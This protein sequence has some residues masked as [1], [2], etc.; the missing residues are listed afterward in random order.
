MD[1]VIAPITPAGIPA[2]LELI[3]ELARFEKLEHEMEATVESLNESFFGKQPVAG[4]L[5]ARGE[6]GAGLERTRAELLSRPRR[7]G[8]ERMGAAARRTGRFEE[9][10]RQKFSHRWTQMKHRYLT[11]KQKGKVNKWHERH[12]HSSV[13]VEPF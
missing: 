3:R 2:L 4:A 5:L 10:G 12:R 11:I 9:I 7:G 1:F 13:P 6:G 8:E